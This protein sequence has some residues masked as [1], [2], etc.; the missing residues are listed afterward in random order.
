VRL[1]VK[2]NGSWS[3]ASGDEI[4]IKFGS[5]NSNCYYKAV[6]LGVGNNE[7]AHIDVDLQRFAKKGNPDLSDVTFYK[8]AKLN[9]LELL[10]DLAEGLLVGMRAISQRVLLPV[11][12]ASD[13]QRGHLVQV[14]APSLGLSGSYLIAEAEHRLN[15]SE[16]YVTRVLLENPRLSLPWEI[17]RILERELRLERRGDLE[18]V[19]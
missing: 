4:T 9:R 7:W 5:D 3:G 8:D 6:R 1:W 19:L 10:Q 2:I 12:G 15:R 14:S 16:G 11:V 17:A 18:V 13:L